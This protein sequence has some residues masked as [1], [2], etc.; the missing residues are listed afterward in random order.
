MSGASLPVLLRSRCLGEMARVLEATTE[1]AGR[2]GWSHAQYRFHSDL[3]PSLV[4]RRA[5]DRLCQDCAPRAADLDYL[6]ILRQAARTME[7]EVER[8]LVDLAQR[9]LTPRWALL[10][11]FWPTAQP[12][13]APHLQP[14]T[15]ELDAY[16]ALLAEVQS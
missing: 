11:E 7:C 4:F 10:Q 6:R 13:A 2:D 16:D 8:I 12:A 15:V 9:D 14:L 1:Q 3:F 5:Y